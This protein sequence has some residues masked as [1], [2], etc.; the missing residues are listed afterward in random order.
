MRK[1]MLWMPPRWMPSTEVKFIIKFQPVIQVIVKVKMLN[2]TAVTRAPIQVPGRDPILEFL[3]AKK[4][5]TTIQVNVVYS[6][7]YAT[8]CIKNLCVVSAMIPPAQG[9]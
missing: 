9:Q 1:A 3:S 5:A 2:K 6:E 7:A 8:N 4:I